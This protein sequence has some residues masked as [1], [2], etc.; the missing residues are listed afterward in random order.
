MRV[1]YQTLCL[2]QFYQTES[3]NLTTLTSDACDEHPV[4]GLVVVQDVVVA[5]LDVLLGWE[6]V[7]LVEV[8]QLHL[9]GQ[10]LV[11]ILVRGCLVARL[12]RREGA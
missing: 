11:Q 12:R 9:R 1:N 3:R 10:F 5:R 4:P 2:M 6:A 8:V 7:G